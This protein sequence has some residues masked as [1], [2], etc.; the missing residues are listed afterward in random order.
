M[1]YTDFIAALPLIVLAGTGLIV[2]MWD[3]FEKTPTRTPLALT[4]I[5]GI[6]AIAAACYN[7]TLPSSIAFDGLFF[8]NSFSNFFTIIFSAATVLSALLGERYLAEHE[9]VAGEFCSLSLFASCGMV[10]MASGANMIVTFLGLETMSIAFYILSGMFRKQEGSNE[11]ALK[12]FLLGAF[13]TGFFLYGMALVYGCT[14]SMS[15]PVIRQMIS[16]GN[17]PTL[18][19]YDSTLLLLGMV[20][21]LVGL[22][23]KVAAFPFH[24]WA[25][26]VY[27]GAP[28]VVAGFMSTAGKA[29]AFS[30]LILLFPYSLLSGSHLQSGAM[31]MQMIIAVI[32]GLSMLYGN[33]VAIAQ[34]RIKRMLAY[35]SIAHAGYML[36]GIASLNEQGITGIAIYSAVYLLMQISAFGI[37]GVLEKDTGKGFELEDY[38]GLSKRR[39][40]LAF[41]LSIIMLSL[42]GIPPF[43]GFFGKYYLFLAAINSGMTWLAI[44]GVVSSIIAAYFY[45][46]VIVLMYFRDSKE[47]EIIGPEKPTASLIAV[48]LASIALIVFGLQPSILLNAIGY[49]FR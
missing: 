3:A 4:I 23:F 33:M 13:A 22:S 36:L 40:W 30:A 17:T 19:T 46:R 20:L 32:A 37:V 38:A 24:Q 12:Y 42:A 5:G 39:P 47:A 7:L 6:G 44:V 27:E 2:L 28:T 31:K 18:A 10:M 26:D 11:A 14:G 29:A 35:S 48:G 25:P 45:L 9:V 41:L 43:A 8:S 21:I 49:F 15:I 16:S 34:T 1:S